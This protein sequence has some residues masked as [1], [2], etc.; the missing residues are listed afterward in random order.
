M[1]E[2][3]AAFVPGATRRIPTCAVSE[4]HPERIMRLT[5]NLQNDPG[6]IP[7]V[8]TRDLGVSDESLHVRQQA[9]LM[10]PMAMISR[11]SSGNATVSPPGSGGEDIC[12][13]SHSSSH[14]VLP[15]PIPTVDVAGISLPG[16]APGYKDRNQ[17][18]ALLL[19]TFL[20]NQQHLLAVFDGHGP[21]GHRVSAFV[22]RNLPYT[23][24][25]KLVE[26]DGAHSGCAGARPGG[27]FGARPSSETA[28]AKQTLLLSA[29]SPSAWAAFAASPPGACSD[30]GNDE[31]AGGSL[32]RALWRTVTSLD[33]QLGNSGIDV[34]NSGSTMALCHVHGRL[35]TAAWVGDSRML[36]GLPA[37]ARTPASA[38]EVRYELRGTS[39]SAT[40]VPRDAKPTGVTAE[41]AGA[42]EPHRNSSG[43]GSAWRVAWSSTDHKP[44]VPGEALRIQ[45]AGGRVARSV[46][47]QGPVGPYRVWFQEQAYPGLAMS[48]ALGDLPGRDIG[49]T[50]TPSCASIRL[51]DNGPAVLVLASDGVWE[52]LS[53]EQVL[54]LAT[55][56]GS[57]TEAAN[58][59]VQQSR[60]AWV[61]EYGGSY[62]DDI[63]AVVMRFGMPPQQRSTS[64]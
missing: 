60:R 58:R 57:A 18:A 13:G 2:T 16:Y 34:I 6:L 17:D 45:A 37:R 49:I 62:V 29:P 23:L 54:E 10:G 52:L 3:K 21:E 22:K 38:N 8:V 20:S 42:L 53:N 64:G 5:F 63:T 43:G 27:F 1:V 25:A 32:P 12:E 51:P 14:A 48:R 26:E 33:Q 30:T 4:G 7:T 15:P 50:C 46:G 19:D 47:R 11:L 40:V 61:K 35:L 24:L 36:L 59:V 31:C 9:F 39:S 55:E 41:S 56:T 44:E 28:N